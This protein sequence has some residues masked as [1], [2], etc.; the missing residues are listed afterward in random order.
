MADCSGSTKRYLTQLVEAQCFQSF[1]DRRKENLDDEFDKRCNDSS[2]TSIKDL[3]RALNNF[4]KP[5]SPTLSRTNSISKSPQTSPR[6]SPRLSPREVSPRSAGVATA[7]VTAP[8]PIPERNYKK[9]QSMLLF[10]LPEP[11]PVLIELE[12]EV[13]LI[14]FE[15]RP[16][17]VGELIVFDEPS[18]LLLQFDQPPLSQFDQPHMQPSTSNDLL[19]FN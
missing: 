9:K 2:G 6:Q 11:K 5:K 8:P 18:P 15:E 16:A 1:L 14:E 13:S 10:D 17:P 4:M 12:P 19:K 3:G 7:H